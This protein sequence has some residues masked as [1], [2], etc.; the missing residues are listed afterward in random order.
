MVLSQFQLWVQ[1][2]LN[3]S[4]FFNTRISDNFLSDISLAQ[5]SSSPNTGENQNHAL[6]QLLLLMEH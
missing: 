5:K 4:I 3:V 2:D 1:S 6:S